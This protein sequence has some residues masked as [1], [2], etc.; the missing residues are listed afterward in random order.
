MK[1]VKILLLSCLGVASTT[2]FVAGITVASLNKNKD[3]SS[4][5]VIKDAT[6]SNNVKYKNYAS[7]DFGFKPGN[8]LEKK[9]S[10]ELASKYATNPLY[11]TGTTVIDNNYWSDQ[12]L[13]KTTLDQKQ[14]N[15]L[16]FYALNHSNVPLNV[17][18]DIKNTS[19]G[20]RESNSESEGYN[21]NFYSFANDKDGILYLQITFIPN[22][23]NKD[24]KT[25]RTLY[26][27]KGFKQI[28]LTDID[29]L[30]YLTPSLNK[31]SDIYKNA[32][33]SEDIKQKYEADKDDLTKKTNFINSLLNINKNKLEI[34]YQKTTLDFDK[35]K[36]NIKFITHPIINWAKVNKLDDSQ[37][38]DQISKEIDV[39]ISLEK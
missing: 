6:I 21:L 11:R 17:F 35:D 26:Q 34:D 33:T 3:T 36:L 2:A 12:L 22:A 28:Q 9:M 18:L 37:V 39:Q 24:P 20:K 10:S 32:K 27:I 13:P 14:L 30:M 5:D 1:K 31:D 29:Q 4:S 25:Y 8:E 16:D 23:K 7:W 15:T 38:Y 19:D